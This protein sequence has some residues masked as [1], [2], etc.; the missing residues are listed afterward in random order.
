MEIKVKISNSHSVLHKSFFFSVFS[1]FR[2]YPLHLTKN[3]SIFRL[4]HLSH[5]RWTHKIRAEKFFADDMHV[6]L[7]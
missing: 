6:E 3:L 4:A 1:L 5:L 2:C 7:H